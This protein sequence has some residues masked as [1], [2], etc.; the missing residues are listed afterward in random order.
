[1]HP[2]RG[3]VGQWN[4]HE[5]AVL[6][7]RVRQDQLL[8]CFSHL[9]LKWQFAP[10]LEGCKI[11]QDHRPESQQIHIQRALTPSVCAYA[12]HVRLDVVQRFHQMLRFQITIEGN[13]RIYKIWAAARRECRGTEKA[14]RQVIRSDFPQ[15]TF[16][17][18]SQSFRSVT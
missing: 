6:Q 16:F 5:R 12:P 2:I 18:L 7:P 8:R 13:G 3:N 15:E 10:S 14:A 4:K 17:G 9:A 1:M 11:W